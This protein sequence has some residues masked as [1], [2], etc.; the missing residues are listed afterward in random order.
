[1]HRNIE[2]RSVASK[3]LSLSFL[4]N[5]RQEKYVGI[6]EKNS[7]NYPIKTKEDNWIFEKGVKMRHQSKILKLRTNCF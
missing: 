4:S 1:M 3:N 5:S 7:I 6:R 2:K